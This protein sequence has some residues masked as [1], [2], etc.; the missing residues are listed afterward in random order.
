MSW[1]SIS[2]T[3]PPQKESPPFQGVFESLTWN[4]R[5]ETITQKTA[6]KKFFA[7]CSRADIDMQPLL[8]LL[9]TTLGKMQV[10]RGWN[11]TS[12]NRPLIEPVLLNRDILSDLCEWMTED[13]DLIDW[14]LKS[15]QDGSLTKSTE[16]ASGSSISGDSRK[17][18]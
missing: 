15:V 13:H 17:W 14:I 12:R 11:S 6:F 18:R 3:S 16:P 5:T 1:W 9:S 2:R 4:C 7:E 10:T 8:R